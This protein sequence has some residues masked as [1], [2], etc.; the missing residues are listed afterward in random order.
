[1]QVVEIIIYKKKKEIGFNQLHV[2]SQGTSKQTLG[3][4]PYLTMMI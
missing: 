2:K 3:I 1:M 4:A